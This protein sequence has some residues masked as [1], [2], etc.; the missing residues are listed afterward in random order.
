MTTESGCLVIANIEPDTMQDDLDYDDL[1][2]SSS[3]DDGSDE[4][5]V[6]RNSDDARRPS[7]GNHIDL[8]EYLAEDGLEIV[9]DDE[10][11]G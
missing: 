2:L 3:H 6:E 5:A 10:Q 1:P 7:P 8:E 9:Y 11:F 4:E